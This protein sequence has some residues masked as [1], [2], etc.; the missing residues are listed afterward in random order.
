MKSI[1]LVPTVFF[2]VA[3]AG[4]VATGAAFAADAAVIEAAPDIVPAGFVWTGGYVG[5]QAG[6]AWSNS[7]YLS[8]SGSSAE[9]DPTG[10]FGGVY[11]GYNHQFQGNFVLGV[12]ADMNFSGIDGQSDIVF[13][14]GT[15][16]LDHQ[17]VSEVKWNGAL[18]ARL[19][20]AVGR[21]MPYLAGGISAARYE[22]TLRHGD[23]SEHERAK[24]TW[25]GWNIGAGVEYAATDTLLLRAE[26]R[27]TDYGSKEFQG[28]W[29]AGSRSSTNLRSSDLRLGLAYRF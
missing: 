1:L 10:L 11:A 24:G 22:F 20:Y 17:F 16:D 26:Y 29:S 12:D 28:L 7:H 2:A 25:T 13:S 8:N 18:R 6:H 4:L 15:T 5:L 27:Y 3:G 14:D 23:G 19:G 9:P 21:F